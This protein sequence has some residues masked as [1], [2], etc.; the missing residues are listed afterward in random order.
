MFSSADTEKDKSMNKIISKILGMILSP[1][2]E[3]KWLKYISEIGAS[4]LHLVDELV[5]T[6]PAASN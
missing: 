6:L 1:D 5:I 3:M 4:Q 2:V